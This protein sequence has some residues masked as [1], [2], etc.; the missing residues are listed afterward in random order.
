MSHMRETRHLKIRTNELTGTRQ[1]RKSRAKNP[2]RGVAA[3]LIANMLAALEW[4]VTVNN[5]TCTDCHGHWL[6]RA[7]GGPD[8]YA[9]EHQ[10]DCTIHVMRSADRF[11]KAHTAAPE[12]R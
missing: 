2:W 6:N 7:S 11:L 4:Y 5:G 8:L 3:P 1:P 9:G 12:P 10:P